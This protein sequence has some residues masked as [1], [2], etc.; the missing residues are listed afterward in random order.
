MLFSVHY[1]TK[2][3]QNAHV[4]IWNQAEQVAGS[5]AVSSTPPWPLQELLLQAPALFELQSSSSSGELWLVSVSQTNPFLPS[6]SVRGV[7]TA[8]VTPIGQEHHW[9]GAYQLG[10]W[11]AS[12]PLRILPLHVT[13]VGLQPCAIVSS[14]SPGFGAQ[15][16]ASEISTCSLRYR[17]PSLTLSH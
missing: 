8:L 3:V 1:F 15:A 5:K 12:N 4:Y 17:S 16:H 2:S 11:L 7:I 9:P 14:I 6:S 10:Y 13:G